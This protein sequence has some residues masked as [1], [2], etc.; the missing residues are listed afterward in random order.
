MINTQRLLVKYAACTA[1]ASVV[2]SVSAAAQTLD[3]VIAKAN[4]ARGGVEKI[5][6]INTLVMNGKM[7]MQGG[8]MKIEGTVMNKRPSSY[9]AEFSLQNMK[10]ITTTNGKE[11]WNLF[12][13]MG[14][15]EAQP[16][17]AKD[18]EES[19]E[20]ADIDGE[21]IDSKQ[22]GYTLEL[23]GKEDVEGA[24]A[25]KIKVTKKNGNIVYKFID[26]ETFL[27]VKQTSKRKDPRSGTEVE[28]T[29][30]LSDYRKVGDVLMPFA[31]E[32]KLGSQ[33]QSQ[34][35]LEKV[36]VNKPLDDALFG[37]PEAPKSK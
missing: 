22:K 29:T 32:T 17:D 7:I 31:T 9:R 36:E 33:T 28:S 3:E 10:G 16:M 15:K 20:N 13:W 26:A 5:K 11:G 21:F 6:A 27:E 34:M 8:A 25:F 1:F 37:K 30:L 24:P 2:M 35:I 23:M 14:M 12:P 18:V 4:E 19:I